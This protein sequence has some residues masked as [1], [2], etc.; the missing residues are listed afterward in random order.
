MA[1]KIAE[2]ADAVVAE[3]TNAPDGT[4]S[5]AFTAVRKYVPRLDL[6]DADDVLITVVPSG[7]RTEQAARGL[8]Q[9]EVDVDL[10]IQ[11][12]LT[13]G[14]NPEDATLNAEIDALMGLVEEIVD[15]FEPGDLFA[16]CVLMQPGANDPIWSPEHLQN[17]KTFTSVVRLTVK[18]L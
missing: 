14:A 15:F 9:K 8:V 2:I 7:L 1:S 3:L 6:A 12:R 5:L 11:K 18:Q 10:G 4:F 13:Q 16:G 17:D